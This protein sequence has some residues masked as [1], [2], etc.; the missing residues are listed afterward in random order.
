MSENLKGEI[1]NGVLYIEQD[2]EIK[3]IETPIEKAEP[4]IYDFYT[5]NEQDPENPG[6]VCFYT[7]KS[8]ENKMPVI[9]QIDLRT[10]APEDLLMKD[11]EFEEYFNNF[12]INSGYTKIEVVGKLPEDT[13]YQDGVMYAK[14]SE[15]N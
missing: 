1:I 9:R 14:V 12:I 5:V 4:G 8:P 13:E 10:Y 11:P 3:Q 6:S 2:G 7:I 15:V